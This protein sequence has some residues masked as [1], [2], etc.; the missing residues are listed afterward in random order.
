MCIYLKYL[1]KMKRLPG[2]IF[3]FLA[4]LL[5]VSVLGVGVYLYADGGYDDYTPTN[6]YRYVDKGYNNFVKYPIDAALIEE[7][8]ANG[9]LFDSISLNSD[10]EYCAYP[11]NMMYDQIVNAYSSNQAFKVRPREMS[12]KY[13]D[14]SVYRCAPFVYFVRLLLVILGSICV[15]ITAGSVFCAARIKA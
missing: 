9:Y 2:L 7:L 15:V 6:T 11:T 10:K 14:V 8:S 3:A 12:F 13:N 4:M 5:S 1:V